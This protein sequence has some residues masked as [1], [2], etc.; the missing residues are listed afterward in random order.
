[1]KKKSG[2]LR[3]RFCLLAHAQ[4]GLLV[5]RADAL[6]TI[7]RRGRFAMGGA[8]D[9]RNDV[10]AQDHGGDL[11]VAGAL[12]H[13]IVVVAAVREVDLVEG[14]LER[15][16]QL[17]AALGVDEEGVAVLLLRQHGGLDHVAD[18][19]ELVL[20]ARLLVLVGPGRSV[21]DA[22]GHGRTQEPGDSRRDAKVLVHVEI[23]PCQTKR[24]RRLIQRH[25]PED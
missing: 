19:L 7:A 3:S 5:A 22:R 24:A 17:L 15:R 11:G 2:T 25:L 20:E 13:Q 12:V 1:M 18:A 8:V 14:L 23:S 9:E 10:V 16:Q 4:G 6:E 21:D